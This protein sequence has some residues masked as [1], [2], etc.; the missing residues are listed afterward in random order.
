MT[1]LHA[2]IVNQSPSAVVKSLHSWRRIQSD[3][4]IDQRLRE[5]DPAFPRQGSLCFLLFDQGQD[6]YSDNLLW[7]SFIK[8]VGDGKYPYYRV[9]MFCRYGSPTARVVSYDIGTPPSLRD[10]A[11][12]SLWPV[13]GKTSIGLLLPRS[14]F[15]EVVSR[16][17]RKLNLHCDLLD[18]IFIWTGGYV[19]AV[20]ELLYVLSVSLS[21]QPPNCLSP[22]ILLARI[23]Q[24]RAAGK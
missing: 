19:G 14:E 3:Q 2:H 12:I 5:I 9:I 24:R 16:S 7:N 8:E 17:E 11:R 21:C 18:L 22:L 15:M 10:A 13:A 20:V 23:H 6:S 4:L 1:L